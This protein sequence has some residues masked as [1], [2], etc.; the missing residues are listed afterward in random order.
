MTTQI[1]NRG[2]CKINCVLICNCKNCIEQ[3]KECVYIKPCKDG[4]INNE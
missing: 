2:P 4:V 1:K 3:C